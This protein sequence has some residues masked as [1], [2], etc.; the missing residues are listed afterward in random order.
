MNK[1]IL[2]LLAVATV[3][4]TTLTSC[5]RQPLSD[6]PKEEAITK[7]NET[8]DSRYIWKYLELGQKQK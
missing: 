5:V 3:L 7:L 6:C 1:K 2:S 4:P 8:G